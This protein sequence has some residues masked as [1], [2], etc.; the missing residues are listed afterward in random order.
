[1]KLMFVLRANKIEQP[2]SNKKTVGYVEPRVHWT[3]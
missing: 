3:N 2:F 1:M